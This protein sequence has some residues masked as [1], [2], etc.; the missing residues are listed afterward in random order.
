[1]NEGLPNDNNEEAI[2]LPTEELTPEEVAMFEQK[3]TAYAQALE[4]RDG[5]ILG[6]GRQIISAM[7]GGALS[8]RGELLMAVDAEREDEL[9]MRNASS[10]GK[11]AS[12]KLMDRLDLET[13]KQTYVTKKP[14]NSGGQEGEIISG[15]DNGQKV[16]VI[17]MI[18]KKDGG[19]EVESFSATLD[20]EEIAADVA[21][22]FWRA[23]EKTAIL[24]DE[25]I[26]R[27][28]K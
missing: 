23:L 14:Y 11:S 19:E 10:E 4:G 8:N 12:E 27:E 5:G 26:A 9:R 1:M 28:D 16:E 17:R 6:K 24:Q 13:Y 18:T 25:D 21:P 20:G 3:R 2:G 7:R 15:F 22:S